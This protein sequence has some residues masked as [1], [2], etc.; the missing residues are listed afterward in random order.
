MT[1]NSILFVPRV[2]VDVTNVDT[3]TVLGG[4]L[5]SLPL[6]IAPTAMAKLSHPRGELGLAEGAG[7][8]GIYFTV[9][10]LCECIPHYTP[11]SIQ[12]LLSLRYPRM[13]QQASTI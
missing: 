3:T 4:T 9:R 13:H 10:P 5:V 8:E 7:H 6:L 11:Y 12:I 1:W 2:M